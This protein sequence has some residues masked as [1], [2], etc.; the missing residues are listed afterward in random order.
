MR[1]VPGHK[2]ETSVSNLQHGGVLEFDGTAMILVTSIL[3][4]IRA[5]R[6]G[7]LLLILM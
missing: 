3:H 4:E 6:C 1:N 7:P 5:F 2:G